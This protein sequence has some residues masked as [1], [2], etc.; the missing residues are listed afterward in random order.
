MFS[1]VKL[2]VRAESKHVPL[3]KFAKHIR[4]NYEEYAAEFPIFA[5][6]ERTA[7]VVAIARWL[8]QTYPSVA[9]RLIDDSY[10]QVK[11]TV[12]QVIRARY[13]KTHDGTYERGEFG[14]IGGVI[15]PPI[16][17]Y[18]LAPKAKVSDT[19]LAKVPPAVLKA[20]PNDGALAWHVP[21]GKRP[22]GKYIAWNVT[23]RNP[24]KGPAKA[25][26]RNE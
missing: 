22:N 23:G 14:L 24:A 4:E 3:R 8:V 15:F 5:E 16:N 19:E 20:R 12:P 26:A 6:V 21:L 10:E 25:N 11:V 18:K 7:R 1:D 9:S 2:E 13:D 17:K